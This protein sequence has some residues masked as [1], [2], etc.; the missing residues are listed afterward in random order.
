[1]GALKAVAAAALLLA[2][3]AVPVLAQ[4]I[5]PGALGNRLH[6]V[7]DPV[8]ANATGGLESASGQDLHTEDIRIDLDLDVRN[9]DYQVVSLLFGGGK[10]GA[11]IDA[12]VHLEFRAVSTTRLDEAVRATSGEN[13]VTLRGTFG[14]PTSRVALTAEEIRLVG[15]G[16]LL[17][18]FQGYEAGAAK[19][20]IEDTVPG[21][22]VQSATF[23]WG[24][25]EPGKYLLDARPPDLSGFD[26]TN[27]EGGLDLV[28]APP[29]RDPPLTLDA[30]MR[31][32]YL[33]RISLVQILDKALKNKTGDAA[34]A[35]KDRLQAQQGDRFLDR[36]AFNLLGFGQVLNFSVP[37]GW[38]LNVTMEVPR[39]FTIEGV[40]DEL[41]A[42][43]DH[44]SLTYVLDGGQRSVAAAQPGLVTLS[45]RF[46]VTATVL[47]AVAL[48]GYAIRL[49]TEAAVLWV[50]SLRARRRQRRAKA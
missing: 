36:S 34:A 33:D 20:F 39:G 9:V 5:P 7:L 2:I 47:A 27:P 14:V 21:L 26:P 37:P 13:N 43:G 23:T 4:P 28:H 45:D 31:L 35:L 17:Q 32:Q 8:V 3:A 22:A 38:R 40:T 50:S 10:V 49:P 46:I 41:A 6:P 15:A 44:R 12:L 24:N 19:G 29:L 16:A 48:V 1:V 25:T 30:H 42:A 18:A 11:D